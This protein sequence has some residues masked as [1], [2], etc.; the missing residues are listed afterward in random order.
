VRLNEV[1]GEAFVVD[2]IR[3]RIHFDL[4]I[5]DGCTIHPVRKSIEVTLYELKAR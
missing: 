5:P 2:L 4:R 1:A 3:G